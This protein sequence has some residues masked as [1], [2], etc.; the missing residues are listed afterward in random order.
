MLYQT[1]TFYGCFELFYCR[2][3]RQIRIGGGCY[4]KRDDFTRRPACEVSVWIWDRP[5]FRSCEAIAFAVTGH[6][7]PPVSLF[8]SA[9]SC[10]LNVLSPQTPLHQ[11]TWPCV[12][13]PT[14]RVVSLCRCLPWWWLA[15]ARG[16][17]GCSCRPIWVLLCYVI[18]CPSTLVIRICIFLSY[19]ITNLYLCYY[20]TNFIDN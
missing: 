20:F 16:G 11:V 10:D 14:Y 4:R 6:V 15:G 9:M 12:L 17:L 18:L 3:A 7:L 1:S 13:H 8:V 2:I 19:R 5:L